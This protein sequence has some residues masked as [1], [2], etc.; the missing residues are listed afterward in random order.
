MTVYMGHAFPAYSSTATA[1][2]LITTISGVT[3]KTIWNILCRL[4]Y[5]SV[6]P[7]LATG[8]PRLLAEC[9]SII[10]HYFTDIYAFSYTEKFTKVMQNS[11]YAQRL[12]QRF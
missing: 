12:D 1:M 4:L 8:R 5:G 6:K 2:R 3:L 7:Q 10:D 9:T 11:V